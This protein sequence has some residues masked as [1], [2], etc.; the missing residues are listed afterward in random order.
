MSKKRGKK[1]PKELPVKLTPVE[2]SAH[3]KRL[4]DLCVEIESV[5]AEKKVATAA[6]GQKLKELRRERSKEAGI[7]K[8]GIEER[9]VLCVD[10]EDIGKMEIKTVR[11]DTGEVVGVRP[12]GGDDLQT[13]ADLDE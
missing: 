1:F 8:T 9:E 7:A 11:T 4:A 13:E 2:L 10:E 12:L 5:E 6:Y 3:Q